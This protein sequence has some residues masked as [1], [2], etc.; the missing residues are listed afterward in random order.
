M[1]F[2]S[3]LARHIYRLMTENKTKHPDFSN[4]TK[5]GY[6]KIKN[7]IHNITGVWLSQ[8]EIDLFVT[9]I[10]ALVVASGSSS[11]GSGDTEDT[12]D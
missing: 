8:A 9:E 10:N 12:L 11:A 5:T 1:L 6:R 3:N 2:R 4:L 7:Y